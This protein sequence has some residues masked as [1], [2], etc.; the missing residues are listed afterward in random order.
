[1]PLRARSNGPRGLVRVVV[2]RQRVLGLETGK[3]A[4]RV[5][6]LADA[7]ADRE[8]HLAEPQHLRGVDQPHVAGRAGRADRVGG[9]GGAEVERGLAGRVVGHRAGVV[10]MRP[11]L[12]VVVEFRDVVDL[13][14]GLDVAVLRAA[15]VDADAVLRQRLEI[16]PAVGQRLARAVDRDAPG[17]RAHAHF[18]L[19]LVASARS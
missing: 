16:H 3:D 2:R 10:V 1:M 8:V 4:E 12:R 11:E 19:L 15:D 6:A 5:D 18:L 14:L 17:P 9:P 7:A 13:V